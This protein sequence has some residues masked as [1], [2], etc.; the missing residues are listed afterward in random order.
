MDNKR[1][2]KMN[3]F[4]LFI[5]S[6]ITTLLVACHSDS[7]T[8]TTK[9]ESYYENGALQAIIHY[10]KTKKYI[11]SYYYPDGTPKSVS[12]GTISDV[13][14][15]GFRLLY[16]SSIEFYPDGTLIPNRIIE[17]KDFAYDALGIIPFTDNGRKFFVDF[18]GKRI[19]DEYILSIYIYPDSKTGEIIDRYILRCKYSKSKWLSKLSSL[20]NLYKFE[21]NI[22]ES[23][24]LTVQ[25]YN[26]QTNKKVFEFDHFEQLK[27]LMS[28]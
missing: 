8:L 10:D 2:N 23:G 5:I 28:K 22:T 26:L 7:Q 13:N 6:Y 12:S 27:T 1:S 21:Y 14:D 17:E 19:G 9:C 25:L 15:N 18:S 11:G 20:F 4:K 24:K 3:I 16:T